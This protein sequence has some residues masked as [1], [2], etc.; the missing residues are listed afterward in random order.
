V[1]PLCQRLE[2]GETILFRERGRMGRGPEAGLGQSAAPR[3]FNSFPNFLSLS[4][5]FAF[6]FCLKTCE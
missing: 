1:G 5:L 3:P 4:F 6:E 2:A